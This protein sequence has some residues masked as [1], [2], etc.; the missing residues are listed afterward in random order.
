MKRILKYNYVL[1]VLCCLFAFL[2]LFQYLIYTLVSVEEIALDKFL[3]NLL[4]S[5]FFTFLIAFVDYFVVLRIHRNR[6]LSSHLALRLIVE[7]LFIV[8]VAAFFVAMGNAPFMES[9]TL[10]EYC[11]SFDYFRDIIAGILFNLFA[12]ALIEL[13]VIFVQNRKLNSEN[14]RIQYLQLKGQMNPHFLFNSLNVLVSLIYKNQDTAAAYTRKLSDVYRYVLSNDV[15]ELVTLENENTFIDNYVEV[16]QIRFGDGL[17]V[18][19]NIRNEDLSRQLPP[20]SI[21]VLIENA[22]KHNVVSH[23][24]PLLID[25]FSDGIYLTVS[26]NINPRIKSELG[27]MGIGLSNLKK[28]YLL[29]SDRKI[30]VINDEKQFIIRLPLL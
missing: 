12:V 11:T 2:L 25:I 30:E 14:M 19:K 1:L 10:L 16:L 9:R 3:Y 13:F 21:Q 24:S 27:G 17:V 29:L 18:N 8:A 23:A 26:N 28:R 6:Y 4:I 22:V 5:L 7:F 15:L 20:M